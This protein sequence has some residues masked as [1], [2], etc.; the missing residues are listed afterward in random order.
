MALQIGPFDWHN[1]VQRDYGDT[2][3]VCSLKGDLISFNI[4]EMFLTFFLNLLVSFLN[5]KSF[6]VKFAAETA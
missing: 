6:T 3:S 1:V 5:A 2:T 4:F